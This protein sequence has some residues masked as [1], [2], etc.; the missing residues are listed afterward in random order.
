MWSD[1]LED[2]VWN[3]TRGH[4]MLTQKCSMTSKQGKA[5]TNLAECWM[6]IRSKF[7]GGKVI[8]RPQSGHR[9]MG[10]VYAKTL[11][12]LMSGEGL[13]RLLQTKFLLTWQ[14][15]LLTVWQKIKNERQQAQPKSRRKSKYLK[16]DDTPAARK[17][18]DWHDD[19]ISPDDTTADVSPAQLQI[20]VER[21]K[22]QSFWERG[23]TREQLIVI[24]GDRNED[25]EL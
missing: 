8:N 10:L 24:N 11:G 13:P 23:S 1:T 12:D 3:Q 20:M 16:L 2:Q 15:L 6:H 22:S 19:G 17:A 18:Y 21:A 7:D 4:R 5:T 9:C 25:N 14:H